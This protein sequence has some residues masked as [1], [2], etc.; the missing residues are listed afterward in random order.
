MLQVGLTP[1]LLA[2]RVASNDLVKVL[3]DKGADFN[4]STADVRISDMLIIFA[5]SF[6]NIVICMFEYCSF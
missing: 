5:D 3:I 2:L 1:V 4:T 6:Q